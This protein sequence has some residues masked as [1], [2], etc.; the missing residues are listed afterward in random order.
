MANFYTKRSTG[1]KSAG[2]RRRRNTI[3]PTRIQ[4]RIVKKIMNQNLE[5][6]TLNV[7]SYDVDML[8][9]STGTSDYGW[10]FPLHV[11]STPNSVWSSIA[12]GTTGST[13]TGNQIFAR[14]MRVTIE[15][16]ISEGTASAPYV[17]LIWFK[18]RKGLIYRRN[19]SDGGLNGAGLDNTG[20][21][22]VNKL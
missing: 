16:K 21:F 19:N 14:Y 22:P 4:K 12:Q 18:S 8:R 6:K 9:A 20:P 17:R 1:G 3:R 7:N 15:I 5:K 13:R 2:F 10:T 11:G